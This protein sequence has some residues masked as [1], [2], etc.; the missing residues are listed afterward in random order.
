M[1]AKDTLESRLQVIQPILMRFQKEKKEIED[2]AKRD[3]EI[4]KGL[5][6]FCSVYS[7][8]IKTTVS[9]LKNEEI[10]SLSPFLKWIKENKITSVNG[11]F[12]SGVGSVE[13][14]S[15]EPIGKREPKSLEKGV[16]HYSFPLSELKKRPFY[17]GL[18]SKFDGVQSCPHFD[19]NSPRV[20]RMFKQEKE[21][22][23]VKRFFQQATVSE[24]E[25]VAN[26][27]FFCCDSCAQEGEKLVCDRGV[28]KQGFIYS[29][30]CD[31]NTLVLEKILNDE[32]IEYEKGASNAERLGIL[33]FPQESPMFFLRKHEI[34]IEL[35]SFPKLDE[36]VV[37][38]L[39]PKLIVY[40]GKKSTVVEL[41]A[42]NTDVLIVS[43]EGFYVY[44]HSKVVEE[45]LDSIINH[46]VDKGDEYTETERGND[47]DRLIMAF[48][49]I[50][51]ELG[52][53]PQREHGKTGLRV[54]CVWYDRQARIRVAIEVETGSGW[55]KDIISTWELEPQLSVIAT[56]QKTDSVPKAL[57]NFSLMKSIPHK[58]LYI[59]MTTKNAY[60][61]EKQEIVKK[62]SLRKKDGK[63]SLD[64]D[65]V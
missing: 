1:I 61:F 10:T 32:H 28:A 35:S 5:C 48:S 40:A 18:I 7:S 45:S 33:F 52:F 23:L 41:L 2:K 13:I 29:V 30:N 56:F 12:Y 31:L 59:N 57:I 54:D 42:F 20:V 51:Q 17:S 49:K 43:D 6:K 63:Q 21:T 53:V 38:V 36:T 65:E 50:G 39:K 8:I 46:I 26:L 37:S 34:L 16:Y 9:P 60:L 4:P 47:H 11:Q 22:G 27:L 58:L 25:R 64:F 62:Y 24:E 3:G 44:N 19:P 55:K 15:Q 14:E